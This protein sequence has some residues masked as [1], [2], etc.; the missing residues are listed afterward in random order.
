MYELERIALNL[1]NLEAIGLWFYLCN[2]AHGKPICKEE[3]RNHFGI[4]REK[5]D[6][7][8]NILVSHHLIKTLREKD[9]KGRFK[10]SEYSLNCLDE[11]IFC[12]EDQ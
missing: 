6:K 11:F 3:I 4:G 9:D 2:R 1:R 7:L 5:T 10:K 12:E 8:I